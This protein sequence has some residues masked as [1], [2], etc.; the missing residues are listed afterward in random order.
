M[1]HEERF[2]PPRL[3]GRCRFGQG[4][5]ARSMTVDETQRYRPFEISGLNPMRSPA[6]TVCSVM[7]GVQ[8]SV[9]KGVKIEVGRGLDRR[10]PNDE[11]FDRAS[12]CRHVH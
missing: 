3:S 9:V 10:Q 5:F 4:T 1:G 6:W 12:L 2:P 11:L 7:L 8:D